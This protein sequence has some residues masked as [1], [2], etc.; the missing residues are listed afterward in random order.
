M[1]ELIATQEQMERRENQLKQI[2]SELE[3]QEGEMKLR[4]EKIKTL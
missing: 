2:L 4:I 3:N 1:E